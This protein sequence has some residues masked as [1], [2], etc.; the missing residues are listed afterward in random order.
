MSITDELRAWAKEHLSRNSIL[1]IADR[2]DAEHEK[3]MSRAVQ[4]LADAEKDRDYNYANWQE[5]RQKVLQDN[6]T[7]DELNTRIEFLEDALLDRIEWPKDADGEPIR[8]GDVMEWPTTGET[9]EVVGI[10]DGTLF[11]VEDGSELADWTGASTK[12]HHHA[13]TVEDVLRDVVTL[14]RNTWKEESAFHFYDVDD[15]MES[16]NI[17]DFAKRLRMAEGE[18]A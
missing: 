14:C 11:Y 3:A 13:P 17:A 6:I 7:I 12:R 15:V 9:F 1:A 5:C 10:G 16:G 4:L 8:V 18:D 2:I